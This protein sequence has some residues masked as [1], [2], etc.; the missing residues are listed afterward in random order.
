MVDLGPLCNTA[1]RMPRVITDSV[2]AEQAAALHAGGWAF[3]P[4]QLYYAACAAVETPVTATARAEF[5]C[6]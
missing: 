2:V 5:G 6:R 4:R 3:T 1:K